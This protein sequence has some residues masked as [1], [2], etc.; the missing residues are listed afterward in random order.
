MKYGHDGLGIYDESKDVQHLVY[1]GKL[2]QIRERAAKVAVNISK[3]RRNKRPSAPCAA[4]AASSGVPDDRIGDPSPR[5]TGAKSAALPG[6]RPRAEPRRGQT[7][8]EKRQSAAEKAN[9]RPECAVKA[10]PRSAAVACAFMAL[11]RAARA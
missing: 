5:E 11:T 3:D 8:A 7:A 2:D 10:R 9:A 4:G 6:S 1:P